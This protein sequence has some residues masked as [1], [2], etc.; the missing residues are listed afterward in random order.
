MVKVETTEMRIARANRAHGVF[1]VR[2]IVALESLRCVIAAKE[3]SLEL[4]ELQ[5]SKV[6]RELRGLSMLASSFDVPAHSKRV[7]KKPDFFVPGI[8]GVENAGPGPSVPPARAD[9]DSPAE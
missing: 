5:S 9:S 6:H 8:T 3:E 1:K 2:R 7:V 4:I